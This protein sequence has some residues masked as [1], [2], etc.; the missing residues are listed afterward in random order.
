[1]SVSWEEF[2]AGTIGGFVG[3]LVEFPMDTVKVL[4]QTQHDLTTR[5]CIRKLYHTEGLSGFYRGVT[6]PLLGSMAEIS[7]LM[8]SYGFAKRYLGERSVHRRVLHLLTSCCSP[9][10]ELPMWKLALAGGFAGIGVSAV[11]TPVELIKCRMQ[12]I[13]THTHRQCEGY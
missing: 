5:D 12:V 3:K 9:G 13:T 4:L 1:M 11:L 10:T 6:I 7:C 8:T 2:G